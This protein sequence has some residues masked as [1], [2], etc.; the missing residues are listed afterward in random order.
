[1]SL[2]A[3]LVGMHIRQLVNFLIDA[4]QNEAATGQYRL[5]EEVFHTFGSKQR[6]SADLQDESDLVDW[7]MNILDSG[8]EF[9]MIENLS[10]LKHHDT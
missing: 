2:L 10:V 6:P 3:V 8:A 9:V 4:E 1:M 5:Q 7:A